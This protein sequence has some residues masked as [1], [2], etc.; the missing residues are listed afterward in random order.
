MSF[1]STQCRAARA[2][3][4]A[5]GERNGTGAAAWIAVRALINAPF[6]VHRY[7]DVHTRMLR[8]SL[9]QVDCCK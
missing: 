9:Q 5:A 7:R 4:A 3:S 6:R 2:Q 1:K 8:D